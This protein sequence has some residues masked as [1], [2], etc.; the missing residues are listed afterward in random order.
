LRAQSAIRSVFVTVTRTITVAAGV[1][2]PGHLG[3]L[4]R[5][6][7]FELVDAV[8]ADT[9]RTERRVR[10]LPS[11]VGVYF[12]LALALFPRLG[13]LGVWS[14]LTAAL[15][16]T[17]SPSGKALRELRRRLGPAPLRE[18]FAVLAGPVGRP[19]TR[20]VFFAG[21]RTV[22]F[23]GCRS[24]KVP[25]TDRN[26]AWLGKLTAAFGQTGY[27]ALQLMSLV[28]TGTRA[29]IGAAFGTPAEGE[30]TWARRLLGNL[31]ATM[32]V[33]MDRGFD[34][35][36]FLAELAATDAQF[37]VRVKAGRRSPILRRL[38][39]GSVL[40]LLGGVQ[41][42]IITAHVTVTCHDGTVYGEDYRLAAT[43]LDPR[44][45]PAEAL[46]R[47][48]HERWE[49]E[50]TYLALRHTLLQGR[51]LRS[52]DPA[53][54]EQE[55]W[56]LLSVYQSLRIA[57]TDAIATMP[58]TDPDRV[59]YQIAV[60]TAQNLVTGARNVATETVDLTGDIGRAVLANLHGP[61]RPRVCARRVKSPLSRWNKHPPGK[62]QTCLRV[63][64]LTTTISQDHPSHHPATRHTT[65]LTH[66]ADP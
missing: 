51:V 62:P 45:Y 55:M 22:A 27:P 52:G 57:V 58:D 63:T 28:E 40:S 14:T 54:L 48:Y 26:R 4:T 31:D 30:I 43:L 53:G 41:V 1:F 21:Y 60:Q 5:I 18:L 25:D 65:A 56:A 64:D 37:L 47:L 24:I 49:H 8:L 59:S 12:V 33:L 11:R 34:A 19:R 32:L 66:S 10:L 38:P 29:L 20:G 50:I 7:P 61:R 17:S 39:D 9:G 46:I 6:V 13:Y 16:Q 15:E 44:R 42:R 23:D 3:E 2:A 36:Q 35:A